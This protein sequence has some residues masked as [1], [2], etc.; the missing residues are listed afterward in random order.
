MALEALPAQTSSQ[1][2]PPDRARQSRGSDRWPRARRGWM[3]KGAGVVRTRDVVA[4]LV[5]VDG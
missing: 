1:S 3:G 5:R 2:L 4:V